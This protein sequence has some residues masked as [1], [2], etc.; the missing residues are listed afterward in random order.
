MWQEAVYVERVYTVTSRLWMLHLYMLAANKKMLFENICQSVWWDFS[1]K[2]MKTF[3]TM[4]L[5]TVCVLFQ[6]VCFYSYGLYLSDETFWDG[7]KSWDSAVCT[8]SGQDKVLGGGAIELRLTTHKVCIDGDGH[9]ETSLVG[10]AQENHPTTEEACLTSLAIDT[11]HHYHQGGGWC[12]C[13]IG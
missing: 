9:T 13:I 2:F 10:R 1:L 3:K 8:S 5:I 6:G 4:I 11:D 12:F 7:I